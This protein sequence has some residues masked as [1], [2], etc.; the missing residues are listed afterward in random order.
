MRKKV[1][2]KS[3]RQSHLSSLQRKLTV[4]TVED[5]NRR[6]K[7]ALPNLAALEVLLAKVE[8]MVMFWN[9]FLRYGVLFLDVSGKFCEYVYF[10]ARVLVNSPLKDYVLVLLHF[11]KD[12]ESPD[13]SEWCGILSTSLFF[14]SLFPF[15]ETPK[16]WIL[17]AHNA[18][19]SIIILVIISVLIITSTRYL[20]LVD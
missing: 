5:F 18:I 2:Q 1:C 16:W 9:V 15:F 13:V 4:S 6:A 12:G 3:E 17:P 10:L 19:I 14:R 20:V 7:V 8:I 11:L